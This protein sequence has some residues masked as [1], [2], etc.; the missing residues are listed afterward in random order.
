MKADASE[1]FTLIELMI[2]VAIIGILAA[3]AYPSYQDS[4]RKTRRADALVALTAAQLA[5]EKW[6]ANHSSYGALSDL[7]VS[8]SSPDGYYSLV[9]ASD[10]T[11]EANCTMD[12]VAP[13]ATTFAIRAVGQNGQQNDTGCAAICVDQTGTFYPANCVR[14]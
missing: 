6:R 13:T 5:Q 4:V 1:G 10:I 2:V 9:V 14:R 3:I 12:A 11:N 8:S 7:R